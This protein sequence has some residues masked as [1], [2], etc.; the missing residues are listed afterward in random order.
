MAIKSK[1]CKSDNVESRNSLKLSL[2]NIE[3]LRSNLA[4]CESNFPDILALCE[5]NLDDSIDDS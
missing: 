2:T 1:R 4:E 3:G 5:T